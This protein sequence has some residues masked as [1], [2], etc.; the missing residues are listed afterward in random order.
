MIESYYLDNIIFF[1]QDYMLMIS[2]IMMYGV[3]TIED[4]YIVLFNYF[5]IF[6]LINLLLVISNYLKI[7]FKKKK[8]KNN[9]KLY[10]ISNMSKDIVNKC[11]NISIKNIIYKN[12]YQI[13][14]SEMKHKK[15]FINVKKNIILYT[16]FKSFFKNKKI[17]II[18]FENLIVD[19]DGKLTNKESID[20]FI[21]LTKY[22]K[23]NHIQIGLISYIQPYNI[24]A[25][26]T[27]IFGNEN[28]IY[29]LNNIITPYH[30]I[31][32]KNRYEKINNKLIK[33][34]M[35]S[36]IPN[37]KF[38]VD[39]IINFYNIIK[40][41]IIFIGSDMESIGLLAKDKIY[42][43]GLIDQ[44]L[45]NHTFTKIHNKIN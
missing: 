27:H 1:L 44:Y 14:L 23:K 41:K 4:L 43:V 34:N 5:N 15:N 38:L 2:S 8:Y 13:V 30:F 24:L 37:K 16:K 17:L 7:T 33:E 20:F 29:N 19:I 36:N 12:N 18:E 40:N 39:H 35:N 6:I 9:K 31:K 45:N 21:N 25:I 11:I 32:N 10:L 42:A 22:C 28:H 3:L 26:L